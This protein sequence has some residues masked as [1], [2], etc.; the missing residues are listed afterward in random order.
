MLAHGDRKIE[1]NIW[2]EAGLPNSSTSILSSIPQTVGI[3]S[4]CPVTAGTSADRQPPAPWRSTPKEASIGRG[5]GGAGTPPN[6]VL[7]RALARLMP[8]GGRQ[9][10]PSDRPAPSASHQPPNR[11]HNAG[12]KGVHAHRVG[13]LGKTPS[14]WSASE[15]PVRPV[16]LWRPRGEELPF[17]LGGGE[18]RGG[19]FL[20]NVKSCRFA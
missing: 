7:P 17:S 5:G 13:H 20:R 18:G 14:K 11:V 9:R 10:G 16:P 15:A 12:H 4:L 19:V 3:E 6:C 1:E 8:A 2:H